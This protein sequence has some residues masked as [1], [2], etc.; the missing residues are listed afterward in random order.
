M[1]NI[2]LKF[3]ADYQSHRYS[4]I[5]FSF[6]LQYAKVTGKIDVEL[7]ETTNE[8]F[9]KDDHLVFSC[10]IN[11]QQVI[12]DYSDHYNR[13]WLKDYNSLPYFK[14]QKT[15][16]S[17][18]GSI[19]LG[20]PMVGVKLKGT[21]GATLREYNDLRW[22]FNYVPGDT[23]LAKQIPNGAAFERRNTVHAM[24]QESFENV[25]TFASC[26]QIDFWKS[27]ENCLAAICVPG[28][29]NNM[30][31][32]GHAELLG[33]GVCTI[34]PRL[35]TIFP[36][37][38]ILTPGVEYIQCKDDYSDLIDIIKDLKNNKDYCKNIGDNARKFYDNT[39]SP[40]QY[41]NW[42]MENLK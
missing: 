8:V 11:G 38:I 23:I 6:F 40:V 34:S 5:H 26:N 30:V 17:N 22:N 19:A 12:F 3:P 16:N 13:D 32:R 33:L 4:L 31:D 29:T 36:K 14:F 9:I 24:L 10:L 27:H 1:I 2:N 20:P 25:D 18:P 15:I 35:D 28:A 21:K 42:I 41:W 39:Y 7:V 37:N